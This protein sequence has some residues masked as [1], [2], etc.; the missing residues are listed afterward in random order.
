MPGA[1]LRPSFAR[2][3]KP[4]LPPFHVVT[5][6]PCASRV[7]VFCDLLHTSNDNLLNLSI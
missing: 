3:N 5:P 2:D 7:G 1:I 4:L 6:T